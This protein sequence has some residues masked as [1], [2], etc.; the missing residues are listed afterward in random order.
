MGVGSKWQNTLQNR[1]TG[2]N[3][4]MKI[5]I[6]GVGTIIFQ[7]EGVG[8]YASLYLEKNYTFVGIV[9]HDI[10]SVNIGLSDPIKSKFGAFI[11]TALNELDKIGISYQKN[12]NY[13]SI[14]KIIDSYANPQKTKGSIQT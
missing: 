4:S 10:L 14:E 3:N 9:P 7:D 8:V 11:T 13:T 5:A 6:I 2:V 12:D 1:S